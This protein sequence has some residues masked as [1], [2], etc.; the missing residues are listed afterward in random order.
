MRNF[1]IPEKNITRRRAFRFTKYSINIL[2]FVISRN[3][4]STRGNSH[5]IR[6][7]SG[8]RLKWPESQV[9]NGRRDEAAS[10]AA[11]ETG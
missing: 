4:W 9:G 7:L 10:R 6:K 2:A 5:L 1:K 11:R 8:T 3:G